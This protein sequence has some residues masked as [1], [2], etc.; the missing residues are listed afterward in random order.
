MDCVVLEDVTSG[1]L[2]FYNKVE[3][4]ILV[5]CLGRVVFRFGD[6]IEESNF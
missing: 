4:N 3:D 6:D 5:S 2:G 1:A